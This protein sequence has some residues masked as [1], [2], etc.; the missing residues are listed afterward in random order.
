MND[1]L[2]EPE[3][4]ILGRCTGRKTLAYLILSFEFVR[5]YLDLDQDEVD[6]NCGELF[7]VKTT[8]NIRIDPIHMIRFA[9]LSTAQLSRFR[10][11]LNVLHLKPLD[12][13]NSIG[14]VS[15]TTRRAV[16]PNS[17]HDSE[18]TVTAAE[19]SASPVSDDE[20]QGDETRITPEP[21]GVY[22]SPAQPV[23][24]TQRLPTGG[25]LAKQQWP[26]LMLFADTQFKFGI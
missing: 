6:R 7:E 23:P 13:D 26:Q 18:A 8:A 10:K 11:A 24:V 17:D 22:E 12:E 1:Y 21:I 15:Y 4:S 14:M 19:S 20:M 5:D 16:F 3:N 25:D 2:P 9:N